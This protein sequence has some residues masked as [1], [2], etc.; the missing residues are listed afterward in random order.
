ML[1]LSPKTAISRPVTRANEVRGA[2][3]FA[4]TAK[5]GA[6]FAV[7]KT[8]HS[9][10]K[11]TIFA[12]APDNL[13]RI[14][15]E[16][17]AADEAGH[18]EVKVGVEVVDAVRYACVSPGGTVFTPTKAEVVVP[19]ADILAYDLDIT[20]MEVLREARVSVPKWRLSSDGHSALLKLLS[21]TL[22]R[23]VANAVENVS[24]RS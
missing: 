19:V 15:E 17:I 11:F 8:P 12:I 18:L 20:H 2:L 22:E 9:S 13:F 1:E 7:G 24:G 21:Q 3:A 5:A 6:F 4:E 23:I 14:S 10:D 16:A